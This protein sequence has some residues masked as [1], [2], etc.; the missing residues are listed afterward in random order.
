MYLNFSTPLTPSVEKIVNL[1][2]FELVYKPRSLSKFIN[3][4]VY[5][6]CCLVNVEQMEWQC[7]SPEMMV[8]GCKKCCMSIAMNGT[9]DDM[10][11]NGSKEDGNF[12]F[13][14]L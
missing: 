9:D 13:F 7:L 1:H 14:A 6:C 5:M 12:M 4:E 8:K 3:P 10:S 2:G 11:W